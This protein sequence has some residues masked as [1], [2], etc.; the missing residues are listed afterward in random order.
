[1]A[2]ARSPPKQLANPFHAAIL[3]FLFRASKLR[4]TGGHFG[5]KLE[6][7]FLPHRWAV[8]RTIVAAT[9]LSLY[10]HRIHCFSTYDELL[11]FDVLYKIRVEGKVGIP[12]ISE[13][14][15]F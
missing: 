15:P 4:V 14:A 5:K 8:M 10:I 11:L 6:C 1:M 9:P 2:S 3:Y 12:T 13:R 7:G